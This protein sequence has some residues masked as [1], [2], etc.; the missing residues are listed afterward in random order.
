[1][2]LEDMMARYRSRE[3]AKHHPHPKGKAGGKIENGTDEE[4]E[5]LMGHLMGGVRREV[6]RAEE[7]GW[8]FGDVG[9]GGVLEDGMEGEMGSGGGGG[10]VVMGGGGMGVVEG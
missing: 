1:M 8:M 2:Q 6:Q 4:R 5:E 3:Y 9:R 7:E 10:G